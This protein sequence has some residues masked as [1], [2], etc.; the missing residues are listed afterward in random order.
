MLGIDMTD[1]GGIMLT[2]RYPKLAGSSDSGSSGGSSGYANT[3]A[4]GHDFHDAIDVLRMGMPRRLNLS[5]LTMVVIS[6]DVIESGMLKDSLN[7][8]AINYRMYS[9]AYAAI[10]DG[11]ASEFLDKQE[12]EIGSRLS[13]GL[14]AFIENSAT[15]G[16]IP[17]SKL[18]DI[19]FNTAFEEHTSFV[20]TCAL[21]DGK[22]LPLKSEGDNLYLGSCSIK[23][24]VRIIYFDARE[25]M[26]INMLRGD[27]ERF[28]YSAD[29]ASAYISVDKP[30][31]IKVRADDAPNVEIK[32]KL[33][34]MQVTGDVDTAA[35]GNLVKQDI[36]KLIYRCMS[37]GVDPFGF[38]EKAAMGFATLEEWQAYDW[39]S[40]FPGADIGISVE[41][42]AVFQDE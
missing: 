7:G 15:L 18:A 38:S 8:L 5:A 9:G 25:T 34:A 41:M 1:S 29:G 24:T 32:L 35:I 11:K 36:L 37:K 3:S 2:V 33:S 21:N 31:D 6:N 26:L 30:P 4:E 17:E 10:C 22:K 14:K 19:Y 16:V 23:D 13:E 20:M 42:T 12:P 39:G 28:A 27:L 40:R